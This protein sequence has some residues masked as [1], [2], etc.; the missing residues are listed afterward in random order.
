[1]S[2]RQSTQK[3]FSTNAWSKLAKVTVSRGKTITPKSL[4]EQERSG[5]RVDYDG[6]VER[7]GVIYNKVQIQPNAGQKIPPAIKAW[8]EKNGG[9]HA[10]MATA[11]IKKDGTKE[12]VEQAFN[13]AIDSIKL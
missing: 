1:M 4:A 3:I 10:V 2:L 7:D 8:R 12:E 5:F 6:E 11:Y 13:E 9:T